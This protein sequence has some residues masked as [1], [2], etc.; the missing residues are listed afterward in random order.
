MAAPLLYF[1]AFFLTV[2]AAYNMTFYSPL[3]QVLGSIGYPLGITLGAAIAVVVLIGVVVF[4]VLGWG[5]PRAEGLQRPTV[6]DHLRHCS[7]LYL[8]LVP[9]VFL[10]VS[11]LVAYVN[12]GPGHAPGAWFEVT[13]A[14]VSA[15]L[16]LLIDARGLL[17]RRRRANRTSA[18]RLA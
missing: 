1:G 11:Y 2:V 3:H 4:G 6:W 10:L 13:L 9:V 16:G 7:L 5:L 18:G 8:A 12:T 17:R 15:T 14:F